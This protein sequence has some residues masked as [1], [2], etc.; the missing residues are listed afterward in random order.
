MIR[1]IV[2]RL[3]GDAPISFRSADSKKILLKEAMLNDKL[4]EAFTG[5]E[6]REMDILAL[7]RAVY[8]S[9][10]KDK[11][12]RRGINPICVEIEN[13]LTELGLVELDEQCGSNIKRR[14]AGEKVVKKK[15]YRIEEIIPNIK[16][17]KFKEN[18]DLERV[19]NECFGKR[20]KRKRKGEEEEE[21]D[22][23]KG[24]KVK[25]TEFEKINVKNHSINP[26]WNYTILKS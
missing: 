22:E 11:G 16:P 4:L 8:W 5:E 25:K 9:S 12:G 20:R 6:L 24:K 26:E 1:I 14:K 15:I 3:K 2:D 21:K 18:K 7:R 17:E 10:G 19:L 13:K 23:E